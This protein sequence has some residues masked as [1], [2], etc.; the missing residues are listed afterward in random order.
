[1]QNLTAADI[2][3]IWEMGAVAGQA[4]R[5]LL[6]LA[7]VYPDRRYP[8]LAGLSL[9]ARN[10]AAFDLR[11]QLFG[12][13]L[14]AQLRC[15]SCNDRLEFQVDQAALCS[16]PPSDP[17]EARWLDMPGWRVR[18]RAA[19]S[20]DLAAA[21]AA[22]SAMA[23]RLVLLEQ[24]VLDAWHDGQPVI[25]ADLPEAVITRI[26]EALD[27]L[28]PDGDPVLQMSCAHCGHDWPARF[29]IADFLWHEIAVLGRRLLDEVDVLARA[30]GW[31]EAEVLALSPARR[32]HYL[33]R[34]SA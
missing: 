6:L 11:A 20:S 31:T 3:D 30:Y 25:P 24:L 15:P 5:G 29:D 22:G 9:G 21:A 4:D 27:A 1:M 12:R 16:G 33:D 26:E 2:V 18:F 13:T 23:A 28:D 8:D 10:R 19:T 34:I 32:R 17:A 14:S 7:A